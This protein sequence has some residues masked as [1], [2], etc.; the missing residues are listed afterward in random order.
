LSPAISPVFAIDS[1]SIHPSTSAHAAA[2]AVAS[3]NLDI[4]RDATGA[5]W[6]ASNRSR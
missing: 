5:V 2:A 4:P 6:I 3:R 1:P